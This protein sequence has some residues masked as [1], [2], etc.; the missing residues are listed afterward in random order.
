MRRVLVIG[1]VLAA[2]ASP[3]IREQ[4]RYVTEHTRRPEMAKELVP[5]DRLILN[6]L[7]R[8]TVEARELHTPMSAAFRVHY[9]DQFL[10]E[11]CNQFDRARALAVEGKVQPAAR[12]YQGMLLASQV[13]ELAVAV[14][15]IAEHA[16]T[17][18]QPVGQILQILET[19]VVQMQPLM[20]AAASRDPEQI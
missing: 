7:L 16:D 11:F 9:A 18:G 15:R 6:R 1:F 3:E 13:A 2:C 10:P 17:L 14:A 20:D 4:C 12:V 8:I 5:I 19:F